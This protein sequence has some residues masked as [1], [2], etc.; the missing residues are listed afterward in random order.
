MSEKESGFR[1]LLGGSEETTETTKSAAFAQIAFERISLFAAVFGFALL[2]IKIMRV[3]HLNSRTGHSLLSTVG[4]IEIIL[5][6]LVTHF[7]LILF[8]VAVLVTWWIAGSFAALR[9]IT[10]AHMGAA[11]VLLFAIILLPWP[12]VVAIFAVGALRFLYRRSRETAE[13]PR[14]GYYLVVGAIAV[15]LITD[16]EPWLS[17]EVIETSDDSEMVAYS[18]V[19]AE[20]S[21]GWVVFL[22]DDDRSVIHVRQD[23]ITRRTPCHLAEADRELEHF[24]SLYQLVIR[25]SADLPEPECPE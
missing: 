12:F 19:E 23:T 18:L 7:P 1:T 16:S 17:S 22:V 6:S 2:L 11:G 25:E 13:R 21:T 10:P 20:N 9:T 8:V 4:P 5:G 3:S 14:V 15:L 24:P